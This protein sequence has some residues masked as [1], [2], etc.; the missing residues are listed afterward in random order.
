MQFPFADISLHERFE[1]FRAAKRDATGFLVR[2]LWDK[3]LP[4][5]RVGLPIE[6][7]ICL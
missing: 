4:N 1:A 2:T 3:L 5:G 6:N 7:E